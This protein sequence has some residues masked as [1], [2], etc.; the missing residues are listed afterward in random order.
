MKNIKKISMNTK[1]Y[2]KKMFSNKTSF[3][4]LNKANF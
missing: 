1:S 2:V 4:K 3:I